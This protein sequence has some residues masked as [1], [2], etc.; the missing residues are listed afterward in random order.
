MDE[1]EVLINPSL[2]EASAIIKHAVKEG[3]VLV[4]IGRC[5]VSYYGRASSSLGLGDRIIISKPDGS[6]MVHRSKG[7]EPVNWMPPGALLNVVES[8]ERL[9]LVSIRRRPPEELTVSLI[10]VYF[11]ASTNLVDEEDFILYASEEDMRKAILLRPELVESGFKPLSVEKTMTLDGFEG[12]ADLVGEDKDGNLVVV[13]LKRVKIGK[14]AVLQ[15]KRY[16]DTLRAR[17]PRKV[18]GII[19]GPSITKESLTLARQL[20][21]NFTRIDP[22]ACWELLKKK[23]EGK[24]ILDYT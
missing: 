9:N 22:K 14:D 4:L 10:Q 20:G 5:G 2:S 18:R 17:T 12:F 23:P 7:Y 16:V 15:L 1:Q 3:K 19:A 6:F 13:E 24:R 8:K 11:L 21:F